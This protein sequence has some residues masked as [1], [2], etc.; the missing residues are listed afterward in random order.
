VASVGPS[1][2]LT[3]EAETP[4]S[5]PTRLLVALSVAAVLVGALGLVLPHLVGSRDEFA[6]DRQAVLTRTSDFV[7]TFNT[8]S[9]KDW[10]DYQKRVKPLVT[11]TFEKQFIQITN[12]VFGVVKD[13]DR[14][15][16]DVKVLSQ[17]VERIDKDSAVVIT[18]FDSSVRNNTSKGA[19]VSPMR[20][21]VSLR[22]VDGRW[23]VNKSDAVLLMQATVDDVAKGGQAQ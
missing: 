1:I 12:A 10:K 6:S 9:V 19:T 4:P 3:A 18:G 22:K 17:A 20:W 8:Y 7:V 15:S 21:A 13:K 16:G 2:E 14:R 23:L 11:P 5:V